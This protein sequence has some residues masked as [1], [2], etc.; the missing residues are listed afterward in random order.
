[1]S[2]S[3]HIQ[4]LLEDEIEGEVVVRP[5]EEQNLEVRCDIYGDINKGLRLNELEKLM[6]TD[7]LRKFVPRRRYR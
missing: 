5:L 1:M 4:I 2:R 7:P 3:T 6:N